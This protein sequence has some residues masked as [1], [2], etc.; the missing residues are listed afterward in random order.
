MM[1]VIFFLLFI[2]VAIAQTIEPCDVTLDKLYVQQSATNKA[3]AACEAAYFTGAACTWYWGEAENLLQMETNFRECRKETLDEFLV[4]LVGSNWTNGEIQNQ[5]NITRESV[6]FYGVQTQ[7]VF[8]AESD[9]TRTVVQ[10]ESADTR[11]NLTIITT[12]EN[13]L[14][15]TN[16]TQEAQQTRSTVQEEAI[17]TRNTVHNESVNTRD[18]L[19]MQESLTRDLISEEAQATRQFVSDAHDVTRAFVLSQANETRNTVVTESTAIQATVVSQSQETRNILSNVITSESEAS[20][21]NTTREATLTRKTINDTA[22][23]TQNVVSTQAENTRTT[24]SSAISADGSATRAAIVADGDK[25]RSTVVNQSSIVQNKI[26]SS[27][28]DI[29]STIITGTN[30]LSNQIAG[31]QSS[32]DSFEQLFI[33]LLIEGSFSSDPS[34]GRVDLFQRPASS[35][36]YFEKMKAVVQ[37]VVTYNTNQY[38][39]GY[40]TNLAISASMTS[41]QSYENQGNYRKAWENYRVAYIKAVTP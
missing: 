30:S 8:T 24:L 28:V 25:T 5:A 18:L 32:L 41:A 36:G 22:A 34:A 26:A 10:E 6:R 2:V 1:K 39:L 14:T 13:S 15:R 11:Q 29:N 21:V 4:Y 23:A 3:R 7:Q 12:L 16:V 17:A 27:A 9:H 40:T 20:R 35:G 38:N 31:I 37:E 33:K 19:V